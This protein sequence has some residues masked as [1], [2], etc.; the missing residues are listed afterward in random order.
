MPSRNL[1][2]GLAL[3]LA[4]VL[5]LALIAAA[6]IKSGKL[7]DFVDPYGLLFIFVGGV[8][9]L[10]VS[11]PGAEVRRALQH[12]AGGSGDDAEMR[13][14][15]HFWEAAGR[16]FWMLGGLRS[17]LNFI[18]AFAGMASEESAGIKGII[19]DMAISLLA[20]LYGILLA[21]ICF[22]PYWKLMGKLPNRRSVPDGPR[23][24]T[25]TPTGRRG[26]RYGA[27]IGYILFFAVLAATVH[28]LSIPQLLSHFPS[29]I[30]W[31]SLLVVLGGTAV[32]MLFIGRV[33][34]G[35][36]LSMSFAAMGLIGFLVA[37]IQ[38]LFGLASP[39]P[40]SGVR[41]VAAGVNFILSSCLIAL[42]GMIIVGAPAED[43]AI[44]IGRI[45]AP[46][47]FS[48]ASWYAFPL[49]TF[50]L[51][52]LVTV[53]ITTPI[54]RDRPPLVEV[55]VPVQEQGARYEA[56]APQSEPLNFLNANIQERNLIYK[57]N[58]IPP[59]GVH[60]TVKLRVII[61]EEGFVYEVKG[62]PENNPV[63]EK[64]AIPAVRKWRFSPFIMRGFPVAIETTATVDFFE[65]K[66]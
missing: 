61:N 24:G 32:L 44:R 31:P 18:F 23:T 27:V 11:F 2:K 63:L 12:A 3:I 59:K 35:P 22:I 66:E 65:L 10:M 54:P 8:A 19:D 33:N 20:L 43:R 34:S 16:G 25:A 42:L 37:F 58:P 13:L 4:G 55:S 48:R 41:S 7:A 1:S 14:S 9:L 62:N 46:A 49:L 52:L 26:W 29:L 40:M 57:V 15:A 53:L 6:A 28:N 60:G 56:R 47:A 38:A 5:I 21:V 64:A 30:Y 39:D 51:L 45:A 17:I 36:T 50:V